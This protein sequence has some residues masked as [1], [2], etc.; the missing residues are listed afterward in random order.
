MDY[1]RESAGQSLVA[2]APELSSGGCKRRL[3]VRHALH[4]RAAEYWLAL[5]NLEEA[6]RELESI[7]WSRRKHPPG[8]Q[9]QTE[10]EAQ[11]EKVKMIIRDDCIFAPY[12]DFQ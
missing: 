8:R 10:I 7:Q 12:S 4:V 9:I 11:T 1:G 5:G 2:E 6:A 3:G